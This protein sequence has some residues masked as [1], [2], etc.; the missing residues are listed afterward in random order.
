MLN[1]NI[2]HYKIVSKLGEGGMGA[3]YRATDTKLNRDVAIKV[4]PETFANDPDRL[5]RFVREAQVLASLSHP[6]IATI[7]GIEERAIVMELIEGPTLADR[8]AQGAMPW[9]EAKGIASQIAA[10][11][12]A[13]HDRGV[14]HRDL[15]PDNVK[16][17]PEGIVKVL[18][19]GLAKLKD[20][21]E[22]VPGRESAPTVPQGQSPT[23]A[24]MIMGT[25]E[26]MAPEQARGQAVDKRADIW[27]FG[28]VLWEML[29]GRRLFSG[30][31][32]SD[33]L[34]GVLKGDVD[35]QAV[36]VA[37]RRL[38]VRCLERDPRKRLR[39]ISVWQEL[40]QEEPVP[41]TA[42]VSDRPSGWQWHWVALAACVAALAMLAL[43]K[44]R[45][46]ARSREVLYAELEAPADTQFPTISLDGSRIAYVSKG[47]IYQRRFDQATATPVNGTEGAT[48]PFFSPDGKSIG[49]FANRKLMKLSVEGGIPSALCDASNGR[50][51]TWT[52]DGEI[53]ATLNIN[54]GMSRVPAMGG[55]PKALPFMVEPAVATHRWP[56]SLP[57]GAILFSANNNSSVTGSLR[58][59]AGNGTQKTLVPGSPYGRYAAGH[60][61][62]LRNGS[63]YSAPMDVKRLE[64]SGPATQLVDKVG[65]DYSS[66]GAFEVSASGTLLYRRSG[67][68]GNTIL[69]W[70]SPTGESVP[71]IRTPGAYLSVTLSPDG[72]RAA[73]LMAENGVQGIA[74]YDFARE[75]MTKLPAGDGA[76]SNLS[77]SPDGD[78]LAFA[79]G[80]GVAWIRAD[81]AGTAQSLPGLLRY[82][83]FSPDGKWLLFSRS[84]SQGN[85]DIWLS[86][87]NR[88]GNEL[89][90]GTP[91]ALVEGPFNQNNAEVS[92][93]GRWLAYS[94]AEGGDGNQIY[95][96]RFTGSVENTAPKWKV[97]NR[98]GGHPQ[99]VPSAKVLFYQS[100]FFERGARF[101]PWSANGETF[102][103]GK[104]VE[105]PSKR[106]GNTG[107]YRVYSVTPDGK[108][109][110]GICQAEE[111][112]PERNL[113]VIRNIT[114][115][116]DRR[117]ASG[118]AK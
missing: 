116:L 5:A 47:R 78:Y 62:F 111:S 8:M 50:G 117:A 114:E 16:I 28:V 103:P 51:A 42:A 49:F 70:V 115:E 90:L 94:S 46:D 56:Q 91:Q 79:R 98:V 20:P 64:L 17:T 22:T 31:T 34:A 3:V 87:V 97:S 52:E 33:V 53:I 11:L 21:K 82:P 96:K 65:Y 106:F 27:A 69:T 4:L 12:E 54:G 110:L 41:A 108:R 89:R 84:V 105:W 23:I 15:K 86:P 100:G 9:E 25:A 43:W 113:R 102:D 68:A 118:G 92:P 37:A 30:E 7:F 57:G 26:Y 80:D 1:S 10:A 63:L 18:D 95:V 14:V 38:V 60:L 55:D 72:K 73:I 67:A 24:G 74:V 77:W 40:L 112:E 36:P 61:F 76:D 83:S 19:F 45:P 93:D 13:A 59:L 58:V 104:V 66:G 39:D 2:A 44:L 99:W 35:V 32:V 81:G 6:N 75:T 85:L 71:A 48:S 88:S 101:L 29:S 109:V 107:P